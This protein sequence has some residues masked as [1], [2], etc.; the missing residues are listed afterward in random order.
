VSDGRRLWQAH[1][2]ERVEQPGERDEIDDAEEIGV[3]YPA[4]AGCGGRDERE[5]PRITPGLLLRLNA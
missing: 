1:H 2:A 3:S 4:L 5:E